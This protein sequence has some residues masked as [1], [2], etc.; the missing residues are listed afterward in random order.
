[1]T[2]NNSYRYNQNRKSREMVICDY[3]W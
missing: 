2:I 3:Y 1:L